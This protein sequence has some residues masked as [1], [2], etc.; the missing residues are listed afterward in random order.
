M[1]ATALGTSGPSNSQLTRT[2]ER[3]FEEA[4]L[5]GELKLNGRKLKDF[6]KYT[7]KYDLRDT[8]FAGENAVSF[9]IC[10]TG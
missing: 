6:P 5:T 3:V 1:A 10:T 4:Q 8:V 2:L 9:G 7:A